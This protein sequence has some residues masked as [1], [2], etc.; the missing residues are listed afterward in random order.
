MTD[1]IPAQ[2]RKVAYRIYATLGALLGAFQVAVSSLP[3]VHQPSWLVAAL[4]VYAFIGTAFGLVAQ[5]NT[6]T[7]VADPGE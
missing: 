7:D 5:A 1:I 4:S 3:D 2:Y 6:N